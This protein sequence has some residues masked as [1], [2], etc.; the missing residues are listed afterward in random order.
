MSHD[1]S[2]EIMILNISNIDKNYV[3]K[4]ISKSYSQYYFKVT[5]IEENIKMI[6]CPICRSYSLQYISSPFKHFNV[7]EH[8]INSTNSTN[9]IM[10]E[11]RNQLKEFNICLYIFTYTEIIYHLKTRKYRQKDNEF[12]FLEILRDYIIYKNEDIRNRN[13]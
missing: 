9:N 1:N 11:L 2:I 5:I 3:I 13:M 4:S 8:I 7:Y 10:N 12:N 6:F